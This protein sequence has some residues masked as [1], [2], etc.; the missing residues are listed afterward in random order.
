M[1]LRDDDLLRTF[2]EY[3]CDLVLDDR[4]QGSAVIVRAFA[5]E[6]YMAICVSGRSLLAVYT[7]K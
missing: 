5:K 4:R 1:P 7:P 6:D 2:T 3:R